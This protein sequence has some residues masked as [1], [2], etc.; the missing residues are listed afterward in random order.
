MMYIKK[1]KVQIQ[2]DQGIV[3][4]PTVPKGPKTISGMLNP[5]VQAEKA[6]KAGDL[7]DG[8]WIVLQEWS[9]CTLKCGGGKS[10]LQRMCVPPK[11]GGKPC[12]GEAVLSKDCNK[13]P[14][15]GTANANGKGDTTE[16]KVNKP[17][18]KV[19]PFSS[20]PQRY[21]K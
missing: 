19:M 15:P 14:C 12:V 8:Y 1:M 18:V 2:R 7:I 9:Q 13:Q 16:Q 17:I 10:Y 3:L 4:L 6:K 20:K 21:T 5:K 11:E